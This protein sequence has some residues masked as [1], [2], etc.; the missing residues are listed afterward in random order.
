MSPGY[1]YAIPI[2]TIVLVVV[3]VFLPL[4]KPIRTKRCCFMV[5]SH[6]FTAIFSFLIVV[7]IGMA[8]IAT[9][10]AADNADAFPPSWVWT[11]CFWRYVAIRVSRRLH[12]VGRG[13]RH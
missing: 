8:V 13:C 7:Y 12:S 6:T 9:R 5:Y 1:T 2:L 11:P 3:H 4:A 10:F